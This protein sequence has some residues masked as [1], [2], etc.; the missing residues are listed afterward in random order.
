MVLQKSIAEASSAAVEIA[1]LTCNENDA[2]LQ[3]KYNIT[4]D[5]W[6]NTRPQYPSYDQE[7]FLRIRGNEVARYEN[8]ADVKNYEACLPRDEC[9]DAVVAGLP[10][11]AYDLSFDGKAVEIGHEFFYDGTNPVTLTKVGNECIN[12]PIC[13]D[14][15]ALLEIQYWGGRFFYNLHHFRVED[16]DGGTKLNG[17]PEGRYS[18]NQTYACLPKADACYTFL[19][20]G[21]DQWSP[22]S[23]PPPSYSLIFDGELVR[24]SDSWLFDSVQFGGSCEPLCNQD[25]ESL[26]EFFMYDRNYEKL[27]Y[28]YE[29]DLNITNP[30]SLETVSS[31]VVP[32]GNGIPPLAHEIMC[33]PKSSCAS[34]YI[35]VPNVTREVVYRV[36]AENTTNTT[37]WN[38][39]VWVNETRNERLRLR[40]MYSL[41]MDNINYRNVLW[42]SHNQTT[43]MGR[44]TVEGLCNT[45]SQDLF[46]LELRT[47]ATHEWPSIDTMNIRWN[48][49]YTEYPEGDR[50]QLQYLLEDSDYNDRAYDLDSSYGVIECVPKDGCDLSFNITAGSPVDSHTV[51]KNGIQLLDHS[52]VEGR[53]MSVMLM[54]PFGQNCFPA[55]NSL[56]GGAIGGIA[57]GCAVAVGA[58]VLG[59]VWYK[60]RQAQ[61]SEEEVAEDPLRESLL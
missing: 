47:S 36:P 34:F 56:S 31:G 12:P 54:T 60:R 37:D 5:E 39:I 24:S 21:E 48:F 26:I 61:S 43:N 2:L 25:D 27:A 46:D 17:E 49:G 55:S 32:M 28:E 41:T 44:C 33:V 50:W 58:I 16:Q 15:E 20:G 6:N 45:Q 8:F 18:L 14:T 11:D 53:W 38:D 29:W 7:A 59:L 51:K 3:V 57:V 19:I 30:S 9:S 23:F 22:R 40:P 10:T 42:R 35:S 52:R 13:K 1:A 4:E